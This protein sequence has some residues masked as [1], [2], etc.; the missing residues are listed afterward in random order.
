[1]RNLPMSVSAPSASAPAV[2]KCLLSLLA[3]GWR[4]EIGTWLKALTT[5]GTSPNSNVSLRPPS[6][7]GLGEQCESR[8]NDGPP[9][10]PLLPTPVG[11]AP[12]DVPRS[13]A[14]FS[15]VGFSGS[16]NTPNL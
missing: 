15:P 10:G 13:K 12:L 3:Q 2:L 6:K 14:P 7:G 8:K 4:K 16:A 9:I 5:P 1:M 11:N